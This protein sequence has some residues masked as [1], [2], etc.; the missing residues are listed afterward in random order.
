M[1]TVP[2]FHTGSFSA[3]QVI[4]T[5]NTFT[6]LQMWGSTVVSNS[7][8]AGDFSGAIS[9]KRGRVARDKWH[10]FD[11][12]WVSYYGKRV[13]SNISMQGWDS[14]SRRRDSLSQ[15]EEGSYLPVSTI[16]STANSSDSL[17]DSSAHLLFSSA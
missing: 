12:Q 16:Y 1:K 9:N 17:G 4:S 2:I 13:I 10:S 8:I 7:P 14:T 11:L 3:H 6:L 15:F 5:S